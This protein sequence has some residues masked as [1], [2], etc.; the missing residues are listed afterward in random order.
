MSWPHTSTGLQELLQ[1]RSPRS[2]SENIHIRD[3]LYGP[4]EIVYS[5]E[6]GENRIRISGRTLAETSGDYMFAQHRICATLATLCLIASIAPRNAIAAADPTYAFNLPEEL[7]S[8]T[9]VAIGRQTTMNIVFAPETVDDSR[10]P[11]IRG[12]LT[13]E[14]AIERALSKTKLQARQA[15]ANSI[16][17]EALAT[18]N[19]SPEQRFIR[20]N[21]QRP[22]AS[23]PPGDQTT[24]VDQ[25]A[26]AESSSVEKDNQ[27]ESASQMKPI[28]LEEVVVTG[29]H[30]RGAAPTGSQVITYDRNAIDQSGAGT[31]AQFAQTM[32]ENLSSLN[33]TAGEY[34][35]S[36]GG[37]NQNTANLYGGSGFN[38]HGLG[39]S[40]TL[41]LING[42][43]LS[44]SG[45]DGSFLDI[46]MIPLSAV[47]R[48]DVLTDGASAIYG[49]DAVAGVVNI[50]L[51]Q[52]FDGAETSVRYGYPTGGGGRE[53][54]AS[55]LLGKSWG[56]GSL[57]GEFE[58]DQQQPIFSDQRD[59]IV[60]QPSG[61]MITPHD[62][63]HSALVDGEQQIIDDATVLSVDAFFAKH[64][65]HGLFYPD[66]ELENYSAST[67]NYAAALELRHTFRH[68]W[69]A[70]LD[71]SFS[72]TD[73]DLTDMYPPSQKIY[74]DDSHTRLSE[75]TVSA[76]GP[77]FS[78][79]SGD[80][81]LA[82]GAGLRHEALRSQAV[83]V[84]DELSRH[85]AYAYAEALVPLV[86]EAEGVPLVQTLDF[87]LAGR[88]DHYSDFGSVTNP[89]FGLE[90][91]PIKGLSARASYSKS[92]RP[93]LLNQ[94]YLHPTLYTKLIPNPESPTGKTDTLISAAPHSPDLRPERSKSYTVGLDLTPE[95]AQGLRFSATYFRT[96]YEDRIA[97]PP[98][99]G[100]VFAGAPIFQQPVLSPY[101]TFSPSLSEVEAAFANPGFYKDLA[102]LGPT[103]VQAFFDDEL[104]NIA[105][106]HIEGIEGHGNYEWPTELGTFSWSLGSTYYLR[107]TYQT[108]PGSQPVSLV[109]IIGQPLRLRARGGMS[110]AYGGWSTSGF[111]NYADR[112]SN[113]LFTPAEP[114]ASWTTVDLQITYHIVEHVGF[115][116]RG[117]TKLSLSVLNLLDRNPPFV[118]LPTVGTYST[119]GFDPLNATPQGRT[120]VFQ[121]TKGW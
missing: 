114:V 52:H 117:D 16:L 33:Q 10:S 89:K 112:Y 110:W 65:V 26:P 103:G 73:A 70:A 32:T 76:D 111:I 49:A 43:R 121:V 54:T 51:K 15:T 46:S 5:H 102:G 4:A 118:A 3:L 47:E 109:N 78:L 84:P 53:I 23:D 41:T 13:L 64:D 85:I 105:A 60:P 9:L 93:P 90:W 28:Q 66:A 44:G 94:L 97:L 79:G 12:E 7:L 31:L 48:V 34:G 77:L 30:I 6:T 56:S 25:G 101:I 57:M 59:F 100:N 40:A 1:L 104:T 106:S 38:L 113:P 17:I 63:R 115:N 91:T 42:H 98:V 27:S 11:A 74:P 120:I 80:V 22:G 61:S 14:Q 19:V 86:S 20:V 39:P 62:D 108:A 71:G 83:S 2:L 119:V 95:F 8:D 36:A 88:Y 81:K 67:K 29:T 69:S 21:D 82:L 75:G 18:A 58:L 45:T 55:Q 37:F 99:I 68:Q 92:F 35:T 87:T 50:I 72:K 96:D 116:G 24:Q 107:N